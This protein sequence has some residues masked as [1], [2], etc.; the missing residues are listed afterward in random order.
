MACKFCV[1]V[2]GLMIWAVVNLDLAAS[3]VQTNST[4]NAT[5]DA[6]NSTNITTTV[7]IVTTTVAN[8]TLAATN[9]S[10]TTVMTTT[11]KSSASGI[12]QWNGRMSMFLH[13]L[14]F[15]AIFS[16]LVSAI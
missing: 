10:V 4:T 6:T 7:S 3:A 2:L 8:T 12:Y 16:I 9:G 13:V 15:G 11:T 14:L 5:V 1:V